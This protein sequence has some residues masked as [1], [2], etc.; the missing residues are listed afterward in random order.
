MGK[1]WFGFTKIREHLFYYNRRTIS[2]ALARSGFTVVCIKSS[3]FLVTL[4][5]LSDKIGR[6]SRLLS[7]W[8]GKILSACRL[9]NKKVNFQYIDMMVVARKR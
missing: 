6:Y 2:Q 7:G 1:N 3:P 5:F 8:S 9:E 4:K